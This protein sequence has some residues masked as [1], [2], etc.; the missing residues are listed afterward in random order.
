LDRQYSSI[1]QNMDNDGLTGFWVKRSQAHPAPELLC[2]SRFDQQ[3]GERRWKCNY[4]NVNINTT[5]SSRLHTFMFVILLLSSVLQRCKLINFSV[6]HNGWWNNLISDQ[7]DTFPCLNMVLIASLRNL[8][9]QVYV[10][11]AHFLISDQDYS[12]FTVMHIIFEK[13]NS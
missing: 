1:I 11:I 9:T 13:F 3:Y 6:K 2:I 10:R 12:W 7:R 8:P 5:A 4:F